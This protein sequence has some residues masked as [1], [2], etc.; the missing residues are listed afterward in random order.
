METIDVAIPTKNSQRMLRECLD[1]VHLNMPVRKL[2]V[3][4]GYSTD[5]TAA[6][7]NHPVDQVATVL[8]SLSI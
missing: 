2:I 8:L 6:R 7:A 5:A 3:V 4:D 1:S